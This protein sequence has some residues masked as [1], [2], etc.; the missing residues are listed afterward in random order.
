MCQYDHFIPGSSLE[1][2]GAESVLG[3]ES[4]RQGSGQGLRVGVKSYGEKP[5]PQGW[6]QVIGGIAKLLGWSQVIRGV[7]KMSGVESSH[8]GRGQAHRSGVKAL[9]LPYQ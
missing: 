2:K 1:V 7:A 9:S 8:P 6:S 3:V 4:S 5:S